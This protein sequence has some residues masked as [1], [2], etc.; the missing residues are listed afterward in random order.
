MKQTLLLRFWAISKRCYQS[1]LQNWFSYTLLLIVLL[2]IWKKHQNQVQQFLGNK[3]VQESGF[4]RS[5]K[6]ADLFTGLAPEQTRQFVA[7]FERTARQE[8]KKFG[9]PARII[10]AVS[11]VQSSAG[12][13]QAAVLK[14]NYF[15]LRSGIDLAQYPSAWESFRAFSL[16][17][18]QALAKQDRPKTDQE[19]IAFLQKSNCLVTSPEFEELVKQALP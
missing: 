5:T 12:T 14:H 13:N 7:R 2:A 19:W 15:A 1:W 4:I 17:V 10:L 16:V 6:N 9:I 11:L 3:Q 8:E 18:N